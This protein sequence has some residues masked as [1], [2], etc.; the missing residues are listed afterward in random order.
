MNLS[1]QELV[2]QSELME[3][4]LG[5]LDGQLSLKSATL[6]IEV[7]PFSTLLT[8]REAQLRPWLNQLEALPQFPRSRTRIKDDEIPDDYD[9]YAG[10]GMYNVPAELQDQVRDLLSG[11]RRLAAIKLVRDWTGWTL[12]QSKEAVDAF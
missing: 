12:L 4:T 10:Y 3:E 1:E 6:T 7:E 2:R 8:G 9:A 5:A 11:A